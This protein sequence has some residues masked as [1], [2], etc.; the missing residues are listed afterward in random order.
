MTNEEAIEIL[1]DFEELNPCV[2]SDKEAVNMA[3]KALEFQK[4]VKETCDYPYV[5]METKYC[6]ICSLV[7][8]FDNEQ[9]TNT[10]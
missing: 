3:I 1:K 2:P 10:D 7:R 5:V 8:R 6:Y 4:K 9:E